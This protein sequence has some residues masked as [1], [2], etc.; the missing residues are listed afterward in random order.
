MTFI[1]S[2][3]TAGA[4]AEASQ[5]NDLREDVIGNAGDYGVTGGS[6]NVQTLTIDGSIALADIVDGF[7]VRFKAGFTTSTST[8]TL[9]VNAT[10]A[11]TMITRDGSPIAIGL[12]VAGGYYE[13][14]K[15]GV[16]WVVD[17]IVE[18][19][20]GYSQS[21]LHAITAG[22]LVSTGYN[23]SGFEKTILHHL[24]DGARNTVAHSQTAPNTV[25]L[26]EWQALSLSISGGD[27]QFK[28]ATIGANWVLGVG[29]LTN[30]G[31]A[32]TTIFQAIQI[33]NNKVLVVSDNSG[34]ARL[35]V[36]SYD[37]ATFTYGA[38]VTITSESISVRTDVDFCSHTTNAFYGV[39]RGT[40]GCTDIVGTV[41]GA[42]ITLGS[43]TVVNAA[44]VAGL[45]LCE[46]LTAT[47]VALANQQSAGIVFYARRTITGTTTASDV[48]AV[49]GSPSV[50]SCILKRTSTTVFVQSTGSDSAVMGTTGAI[51]LGIRP[52][53]GTERLVKKAEVFAVNDDYFFSLV[54][55][56]ITI[57]H[58]ASGVGEFND[59][60]GSATIPTT[61]KTSGTQYAVLS[62]IGLSHGLKLIVVN[63]A[64]LELW[65][66]YGNYK[67][68][69][70]VAA[71]TV[72]LGATLFTSIMGIVTLSGLTINKDYYQDLNGLLSTDSTLANYKVGR[73]LS[74]TRMYVNISRI[75]TIVKST[76]GVDF[77]AD[78]TVAPILV[79]TSDDWSRIKYEFLRGSTVN[80][81][82]NIKKVID[83]RG[84]IKGVGADRATVNNTDGILVQS[85]STFNYFDSVFDFGFYTAN[86]EIGIQ[87]GEASIYQI[88]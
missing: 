75:K 83:R 50:L 18:N 45:C 86:D 61:T 16:N 52:G 60:R 32:A 29:S 63:G 33:A 31:I 88:D 5:Y 49:S 48:T 37:G 30:T 77:V 19:I 47:K 74:T 54:G 6:A 24:H 67:S 78:G 57:T 62:Q 10:G 84:N 85:G 11:V 65:L 76:G 9:N 26:N 41:S 23:G 4:Q 20:D 17:S 70:G 46:V 40:G 12:I 72:A 82:V 73:A 39:Y 56:A 15:L 27:I 2:V 51:S 66:H 25:E 55:T 38:A 69:A 43:A 14:V 36:I 58:L 13:A 79:P 3:T 28:L 34:T 80:S 8:P 7:K 68:V 1:S 21:A 42:T 64:N 22:D 35:S 71:E 81:G 44:F 53:L 59:T 87:A